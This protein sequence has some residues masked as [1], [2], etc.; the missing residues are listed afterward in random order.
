MSLATAEN[1]V[2]TTVRV[3]CR[4]EGEDDEEC[5][6]VSVDPN[7]KTPCKIKAQKEK[8]TM[9]N[10]TMFDNLLLFV[11]CWGLQVP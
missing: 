5:G 11:L 1:S 2:A 7:V 4:G 10:E 3:Q 9:E 6:N 8:K